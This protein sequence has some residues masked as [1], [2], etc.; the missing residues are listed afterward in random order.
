MQR[1]GV[2]S[3]N[4]KEI[5]SLKFAKF[6]IGS[7]P[8][9]ETRITATF[10]VFGRQAMKQIGR[11]RKRRIKF[12]CAEAEVSMKFQEERSSGHEVLEDHSLLFF[13]RT[14]SKE[15]V[16]VS[17]PFSYLYPETQ[18]SVLYRTHM[19]QLYPTEKLNASKQYQLAATP[20]LNSILFLKISE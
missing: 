18:D 13:M 19:M 16:H 9:G 7:K 3:K 12:E 2:N 4:I 15:L 14:L 10:F 1:R 8:K 20:Y 5:E 11:K 6:R 17:W